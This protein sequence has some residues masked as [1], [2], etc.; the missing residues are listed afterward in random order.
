MNIFPSVTITFE[1]IRLFGLYAL[2]VVLLWAVLACVTR[3]LALY[4]RLR[5][6]TVLLEVIPPTD[7]EI[8]AVST[9]QLFTLVYGLLRQRTLAD[10]FLQRQPTCSLEITSSKES[11]IRYILR[12]PKSMA[13]TTERSLRAYLPALKV[14][15]T[16]EYLP[17]DLPMELKT[18]VAEFGLSSHSIL[19]LN[20]QTDLGRHDPLSYI[21]S[22]MTQLS[23]GELLTLQLVVQP[24][25]YGQQK[26]IKNRAAKLQPAALVTQRTVD[27][28]ANVVETAVGLLM[29]PLLAAAEFVTSQKP[30]STGR[31]ITIETETPEHQALA[32]SV[33]TKLDQPLFE[34]SVRALLINELDQLKAR[35]RGLLASFMSFTHPAGQSLVSRRNWF[36]RVGQRLRWWQFKNRL[37]T[38]RLLLSSAEVGA[39]YH[40][41]YSKT[42][43]T[44]DL[45]KS[46]SRELPAPLTLKNNRDLDTVF[47]VN[48]YGNS[49]TDIGLT[50]DERSRH[51]YLIGQTGSGKSTAMFHMAR[52]DI[53]RGRGL[54]VID[55]HGDLAEDLLATVPESR[56]DD[57]IYFNPF[58][59]KYPVGINLLELPEGLDGDEMELEK[60]LTCESVVSVFRRIF[61]KDDNNDAHRIEYVLRNA[62]HTA[63]TVEDATIFTV[64]ELLN[65]PKFQ[66][67]VISRLK[68]QNLKNFWKNEFGKAG[69]Y[70]IV[71]MVSGVTAKIGRLLFSPIAKRILEQPK[72][73]INFEDILNSEK[74]LLCN[75]A[76][77]KL[78]EDTAQL[79]GTMIIAKIHQAALRRAR[80]ELSARKPFYLFIDEF[81]NFA[82]SSFTKLMSG[83]RKFGLRITIAEQ[84]T[85][86][87]SDRSTVEVILAN[88]GVVVTFRTASP[89]DE[90]T[91]LA[92]FAPF[93]KPGDISNL[94][95]HHFYMRLSSL[96][97]EDPFSGVTIPI[98]SDK[99]EELVNRLIE[100]S[101]TNYAQRYTDP[102]AERL[103]KDMAIP[104]VEEHESLV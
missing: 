83:G 56:I 51:M 25:S 76:E 102:E 28:V 104:L 94:P 100:F 81:Q 59:I 75:L 88:T 78:G 6:E 86:Q 36:G 16:A 3:L 23:E 1:T 42:S 52:G 98:S 35:Q 96:Q 15:E 79:L 73:T 68:D 31:K 72:S 8:P 90:E 84:S 61:N 69:N 30:P 19:P 70:Q 11:G 77:G 4:Q 7:T 82:T 47:A 49:S 64:Y 2:G 80:K 14:R 9:A 39:L 67:Q 89:V 44:E 18:A 53:R 85:A 103:L 74:I 26:R 93:V 62:I 63:F 33:K 40:F 99:N 21:T 37:N 55:P 58:D 46:K 22:N 12:V 10:R 43:R 45:V 87:Q 5:Q 48:N 95:R 57:L 17:T 60:E 65:N 101:R 24:V 71:K 29:I 32:E 38:K 97:A 92:Q 50:D 34:T 41:P 27:R 54:A 20:Y 66:K 13:E 91:M